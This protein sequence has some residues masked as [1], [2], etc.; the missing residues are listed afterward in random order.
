MVDTAY[1]QVVT[2]P[3]RWLEDSHGPEAT[4]WLKAQD[5]YTRTTLAAIPGRATFLARVKALDLGSTLV[6][7]TQV[8]G[9]RI[10]YLKVPAG[11]D[12][13]KLFVRDRLGAPE[14]LLVDPER[15]TTHDVHYSIDYF[16]PSTDG[17]RVAYGISA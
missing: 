16:T 1:G 13:A 14:R 3:Y 11:S 4:Q 15:L 9:G 5:S 6:R 12:N 2:D 17:E 7:G 8:W 10:F